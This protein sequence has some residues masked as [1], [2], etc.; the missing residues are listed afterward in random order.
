MQQR[1]EEMNHEKVLFEA[2]LLRRLDD[3][4]EF[5]G[6]STKVTIDLACQDVLNGIEAEFTR[7]ER[8]MAH[9]RGRNEPIFESLFDE[10]Y[11]ARINNIN[12][13]IEELQY[14][15]MERTR[16]D[17]KVESYLAGLERDLPGEG[18]TIKMAFQSV[19]EELILLRADDHYNYDSRPQE[20]GAYSTTT[21]GAFTGT[22]PPSYSPWLPGDTRRPGHP[23]Q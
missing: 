8:F 14:W 5:A 9:L 4:K 13:K 17:A 10:L 3:Y 20:D 7:P 23:D 15:V 2:K 22:C 18:A 19:M 12:V 11:Q 6:K 1:L 16:R 21:G